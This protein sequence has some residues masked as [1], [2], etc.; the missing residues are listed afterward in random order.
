MLRNTLLLLFAAF[1][2]CCVSQALNL[3][4]ILVNDQVHI[5][6]QNIWNVVKN[7][8]VGQDFWANTK[9]SVPERI[10]TEP[11]SFMIR[12]PA[13]T[14]TLSQLVTNPDS[15]ANGGLL[16]VTLCGVEFWVFEVSN[17]NKSEFKT[18]INLN[19]IA[20][21]T[22][23]QITFLSNRFY[24][25][26]SQ[27]AAPQVRILD[28]LVT[29]ANQGQRDITQ[30]GGRPLTN[31]RL[32]FGEHLDTL[33]NI[34]AVGILYNAIGPNDYQTAAQVNT[35]V[36]NYYC[37]IYDLLSAV[38]TA[39]ISSAIPA[40]GGGSKLLTMVSIGRNL[41]IAHYKN[42][43]PQSVKL[44]LCS[45][46][47]GF[48]VGTCSELTTGFSLSTG[49][50]MF[51]MNQATGLGNIYMIEISK[52]LSI[53]CNLN[54]VGVTAANSESS[55]KYSKA[56]INTAD[57]T[58]F[59]SFSSADPSF[60]IAVY[61][62]PA[63][64]T[65]V[66]GLSP[67]GASALAFKYRGA[68]GSI[69][70]SMGSNIMLIQDPRAVLIN[71]NSTSDLILLA[72]GAAGPI[73]QVINY[74]LSTTNT[75][76]TGALTGTIL[77]GLTQ[78]TEI[79]SAGNMKG[80]LTY[81]Q[82]LPYNRDRVKGN[83][84]TVTANAASCDT[85]VLNSNVVFVGFDTSAT[86]AADR[87][88][89]V[90]DSLISVVTNSTNRTLLRYSVCKDNIHMSINSTC[91]FVV[92]TEINGDAKWKYIGYLAVQNG[93]QPANSAVFSMTERILNI[94]NL[95]NYLLV[96]T[97]DNSPTASVMLYCF[98]KRTNTIT[99]YN[100][101]IALNGVV[102]LDYKKDLYVS[103]IS[104]DGTTAYLYKSSRFLI[105]NMGQ[106]GI[107]N[108]IINPGDLC[109]KGGGLSVRFTPRLR[110]INQ[111]TIGK[112][113]FIEREFTVTGT[114]SL[115]N[116]FQTI[117]DLPAMTAAVQG[118]V[119]GRFS[120]FWETG[121]TKLY[122]VGAY[123]PDKFNME[124]NTFGMT[125]INS[126]VCYGGTELV[127][128]SGQDN[129]A[130]RLFLIFDFR[131]WPSAKRLP[132]MFKFPS[133][134][135]TEFQFSRFKDK[136][137]YLSYMDG[138]TQRYMKFYLGGPYVYTRTNTTAGTYPITVVADSGVTNQNAVTNVEFVAT[139]MTNL[140]TNVNK[141]PISVGNH[142]LEFLF[143]ITGPVFQV[144]SRNFNPNKSSIIPRVYSFGVINTTTSL[145]RYKVQG[146][147]GAYLQSNATQTYLILNRDPH[148]LRYNW[149]LE[150]FA[151]EQLAVAQSVDL[152][153][154][155]SINEG[156]DAFDRR[157]YVHK[158]PLLPNL[159]DIGRGFIA[160]PFV[161]TGLQIYTL[162]TTHFLVT[163]FSSSMNALIQMVVNFAPL[164]ASLTQIYP[165]IQLAIPT[166]S[167]CIT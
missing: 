57:T 148:N 24:V 56:P 27:A 6:V 105:A 13:S 119:A 66:E 62:V 31:P 76:L 100:F 109:I 102:L 78:G 141:I 25:V 149:S 35:A 12:N 17:Q 126:I 118:C 20:S 108:K 19:S 111:C 4:E 151:D 97:Q 38:N 103:G 89:T 15:G 138:T 135:I 26:C 162:N 133:N 34:K 122:G 139:I 45:V 54:L 129:T 21:Y 72:T 2:R 75:S 142:S 116:T 123:R 37:Y 47:N 161:S 163:L 61:R 29:D 42:P 1:F 144:S 22:C 30:V 165:V 155:F 50:V 73:N 60:G 160:A 94:E 10:V 120:V 48:N 51:G 82:P 70:T 92:E 87:N 14:C 74:D 150:Y 132:F 156:F 115:Q 121:K 106:I 104:A 91:T 167:N 146:Q 32:V 154:A 46:G 98:Y 164:T 80:V 136:H 90:G 96:T 79:Q 112:E 49:T 63:G 58:T 86:V 41:A 157:I 23:N 84:L 16:Y 158:T 36:T 99:K 40:I 44:N 166:G 59:D 77:S 95:D 33:G 64:I 137:L 131:R 124:L 5:G 117:Q 67:V 127:I 134:A 145:S 85:V 130:I 55:C 107:Y 101:S 39:P 125:T 9:P 152:N 114:R 65:V 153:Y 52:N 88:Y 28:F 69:V 110:L 71:P 159:T 81:L 7:T 83:A 147:V 68:V 3:G 11:Q 113:A 93:S 18:R 128:V 53:A 8:T 43:A 140:V 143:T